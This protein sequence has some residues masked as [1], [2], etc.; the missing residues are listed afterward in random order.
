MVVIDELSSFKSR[1]SKRF[2]ALMKVRPSVKRIVGLTGTP[3][4]N[5]LMDLWAEFRLLDMGSG[6]VDSSGNTGTNTSSQ[7]SRT[8]ISCIPT[9][10]ASSSG[11]REFP[12]NTAFLFY[13]FCQ[14][15]F[16]D[17][18]A[19][20]LPFLG[21]LTLYDSHLQTLYREKF[22]TFFSPA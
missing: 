22:F 6:S 5:G 2:K 10:A 14:F 16:N 9:R 18:L 15:F 8:A 11:R 12:A 19:W 21:A 13:R 17:F 7:T 3:A 4:S 20:I 1:Q